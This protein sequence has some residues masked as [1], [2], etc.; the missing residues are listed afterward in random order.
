MIDRYGTTHTAAG[1]D[2][3]GAAAAAAGA[4]GGAAAAAAGAGAGAAADSNPLFLFWSPHIA[5]TPL[6]V[7]A[8]Y[9][10]KF[11]FISQPNRRTYHAMV[12]Y[13]G[14]CHHVITCTVIYRRRY[15]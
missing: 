4:G 11:S 7:P 3:A 5:H 14:T 10:E 2:A 6:Q 9:E 12:N 8:K 13:I 1:A 15:H